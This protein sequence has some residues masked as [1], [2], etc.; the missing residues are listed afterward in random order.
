MASVLVVHH[1]RTGTCRTLARSLAEARHWLAGEVTYLEARE[2]YWP[3]ARDALLRRAPR[4]RY[5]GP[6]PA[7][8]DVVVLVSPIWCWRLSP[9]MRSFVRSMRGKLTKVAVLSCMGGSGAANAVAE[10][11]RLIRRPVVATLA[12]RQAD[13]AASRHAAALQDFADVV[14]ACTAD[15]ARHDPGEALRHAA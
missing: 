3:C 13:V 8:V 1:S 4:I 10:V 9:P 6:D 11:E 7:V 5:T 2:A 12:L 14:A 15:S